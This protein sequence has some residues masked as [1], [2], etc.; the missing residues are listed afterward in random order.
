L[1]ERNARGGAAERRRPFFLAGVGLATLGALLLCGACKTAPKLPPGV[2]A[3]VNGA[4][5][6]AQEF[7]EQFAA[8]QKGGIEGPPVGRAEA[9]AVQMAFLDALIDRLLVQQTAARLGVTVDEAAVDE[10]LRR[11]QAG[12]PAKA[13]QREMQTQQQSLPW[14][15]EQLRLAR[16]A[17][18]LAARVIEPQVQIAETE[19]EEYF[20]THPDQFHRPE[21]AHLRQVICRERSQATA[22]LTD[23][24]T[25]RDFADAARAYSMAPEADRGGD[26]GF[27][28]RGEMPPE[29]EEAAF[30]LPLG[31]IS[32]LIETPFGLHI[33]QV[34]ERAPATTLTFT[35]ARSTIE[36]ALRKQRID[37]A[38][39]RYREDLRRA[40]TIVAD[41]S[42]LPG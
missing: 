26:L 41:P 2:L 31:E 18:E 5:V 35:Q 7:A 22:A 21:Q 20:Q 9:L 12:W 29:I 39:R 28:A 30:R 36:R 25:G 11:L 4:T 15:R 8:A 1:R 33:I 37:E 23:L 34:L 6:T 16:L 38:W 40:A 24:L 3:Q 42:R 10:E 19:I 13:F 17:D 27:V 14:L 32:T